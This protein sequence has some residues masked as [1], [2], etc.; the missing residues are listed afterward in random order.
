[1]LQLLIEPHYALPAAEKRIDSLWKARWGEY[2][3][4]SQLKYLGPQGDK[5]T[6]LIDTPL[7]L[8][9]LYNRLVRARL[10]IDIYSEILAK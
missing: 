3:V 6:R 8:Y 5:N 1:M 7:Q 9:L 4:E 10:E 2:V